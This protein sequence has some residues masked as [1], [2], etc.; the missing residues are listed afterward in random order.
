VYDREQPAGLGT[1]T[2]AGTPIHYLPLRAPVR[3]RGV[4][5]LAPRN[6]RL[7]FV[8]EQHRLLET[9]AAQ[10]ALALERVH[11]VEVAQETQLRMATERLRTSLLAS[12]SHDLRTPL[13]VL[14]G[15]ASSLADESARLSA[16]TRRELALTIYEEAQHMSE[17]TGKVLDM[18]RLEAGAVELNRQWQPLD[19]V[20]GPVLWRMHTRLA[21]RPVVTDLLHAPALAWLDPVLIG[22]VLTNLVD[23][24]LKYTPAGTSIEIGA[25]LQPQGVR[26]CVADRG[27]GLAPGEEQRVFDKFYR[28]KSEG[29]RGGV[30]LGL[31]ICKAVV[32]AH[33]G[34]IWAENRP[35]GGA[36]FCFLLPQPEQLPPPHPEPATTASDAS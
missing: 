3:S 35:D 18:A 28:A 22:Q 9:F 11:F 26:V 24:A 32:E 36:R 10:I 23:N 8:P 14:T 4:L 12:I 34:R 33:G 16:E 1:G 27:P 15:A 21:D 13:A 31:T 19:E 30:G 25:D 7:I 17:L 2:L 29:G 5:A 20:V 6:E